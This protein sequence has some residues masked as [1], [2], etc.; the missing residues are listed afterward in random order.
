MSDFHDFT[1]STRMDFDCATDSR[2]EVIVQ[3]PVDDYDHQQNVCVVVFTDE[4]VIFDFYE[5]GELSRTLGRTY[6][7]WSDLAL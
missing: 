3:L 6:Q 5:N 1:G 7:E 4:G 2:K